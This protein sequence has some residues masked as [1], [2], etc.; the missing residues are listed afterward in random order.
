MHVQALK[1]KLCNF[2]DSAC[3]FSYLYLKLSLHDIKT[4]NKMY[5]KLKMLFFLYLKWH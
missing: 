3:K 1:H 4:I 5:V 2:D